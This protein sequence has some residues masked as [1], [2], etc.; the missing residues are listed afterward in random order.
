MEGEVDVNP[1]TTGVTSIATS[2][3][4]QE[5]LVFSD[6]VSHL[7]VAHQESHSE[8]LK[9]LDDL[10]LDAPE[11]TP[12]STTQNN[13]NIGLSSCQSSELLP[14]ATNPSYPNS[15]PESESESN[16]II[17][18][19]RREK[20]TLQNMVETLQKTIESNEREYVQRGE[21]RKVEALQWERDF[22]EFEENRNRSRLLEE[23]VVALSKRV[24]EKEQIELALVNTVRALEGE[25]S[26]YVG[27]GHLRLENDAIAV[28][29]LDLKRSFVPP[30]PPQL[31]APFAPE[32]INSEIFSGL[33]ARIHDLEAQLADAASDVLL[34][35]TNYQEMTEIVEIANT[36]NA[37]I[38]GIITNLENQ[39]TE[40]VAD[41]EAL[42]AMLATD[43]RP[44]QWQTPHESSQRSHQS[45]NQES[46]DSIKI[47]DLKTQIESLNYKIL[48]LESDVSM[49]LADKLL[50]ETNLAE[51]SLALE[52]ETSKHLAQSHSNQIEKEALL[53]S[54]KL[55]SSE[56][57]KLAATKAA[58]DATIKELRNIKMQLEERIR[59]MSLSLDKAVQEHS[60]IFQL[61][62]ERDAALK[63]LQAEYN[64]L[65]SNVSTLQAALDL[66]R[67]KGERMTLEL[68]GTRDLQRS[69]EDQYVSN[70][71]QEVLSLKSDLGSLK[72]LYHVQTSKYEDCIEIGKRDLEVTKGENARLLSELESQRNIG[73]SL[74]ERI[75][76]LVS[77]LDLAVQGNISHEKQAISHN[78]MISALQDQNA[79]SETEIAKLK[80]TTDSLILRLEAELVNNISKIDNLKGENLKLEESLKSLRAE[81]VELQDNCIEFS[82]VNQA[83]EDKVNALKSSIRALKSQQESFKANESSYLQDIQLLEKFLFDSLSYLISSESDLMVNLKKGLS[84]AN[85]KS[86]IISDLN[87]ALDLVR[88]HSNMIQQILE[89][90][91]WPG[92]KQSV[93]PSFSNI[94]SCLEYLESRLERK[95]DAISVPNPSLYAS[96]TYLRKSPTTP[97]IQ[98]ASI[99]PIS[100][101]LPLRPN[102]RLS[103]HS[104]SSVSTPAYTH[105]YNR[106]STPSEYQQANNYQITQE[107]QAAR[108]EITCL[109][110]NLDD[111][112][113]AL[114]QATQQS[115]R[116]AQQLSLLNMELENHQRNHQDHQHLLSR[117]KQ[118][119]LQNSTRLRELESREVLYLKDLE[120]HAAALDG[121][122]AVFA[123]KEKGFIEIMDRLEDSL[124]QVGRELSFRDGNSRGAL[125]GLFERVL[126]S[127]DHRR[128]AADTLLV[129]QGDRLRVLEE[130]LTT[131]RTTEEKV[132]YFEMRIWN[133][134]HAVVGPDILDLEQGLVELEHGIHYY[135]STNERLAVWRSDLIFQKRYFELRITDLM[136]SERMLFQQLSGTDFDV[137]QGYLLDSKSPRR[138]WKRIFLVIV[139]ALRFGIRFV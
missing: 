122:R 78:T 137:S 136:E 61:Y 20:Q 92:A 36:E 109:K 10:A 47:L 52:T 19:L 130:D 7:S 80:S 58:R 34:A 105:H 31:S 24:L 17:S 22:E 45:Q 25:L 85:D 5:T 139:G 81:V 87:A 95:V 129:E 33:R 116:D 84:M 46:L 64:G 110:A 115:A 62:S 121:M 21:Q 96:P 138:K 38:S 91:D 102:S 74:N 44:S 12:L 54:V 48:Q 89:K 82:D 8:L 43:S 32:Y 134:I 104:S 49:A 57:T 41:N 94:E 73:S 67:E 132:Q 100:I 124:F 111:I 75:E 15:S 51:L 103:L 16:R 114:H 1:T 133:L 76:E 77:Q 68:N 131:L 2:P 59:E 112:S 30:Q 83:L 72:A 90:V 99:I 29:S 123:E 69:M 6:S 120:A 117:V 79:R 107:L 42:K 126:E 56:K 106:N 26:L 50:A 135:Q 66:E 118:V 108:Q 119:E 125:D 39:I 63:S 3:D 13:S 71:Q 70:L 27:T 35:Q 60:M 23:D 113:F 88:H 101:D 14:T 98:P 18:L 53:E 65:A 37:R 97:S 9:A 128:R 86:K 11:Q 40:L 55:L 4:H 93:T 127:L 28:N